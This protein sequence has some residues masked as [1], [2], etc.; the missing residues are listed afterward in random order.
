MP[1]R[2]SALPSGVKLSE[3]LHEAVRALMEIAVCLGAGAAFRA[4][5]LFDAADAQVRHM[6]DTHITQGLVPVLSVP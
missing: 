3:M 4:F 6:S 2:R 1:G 5:G